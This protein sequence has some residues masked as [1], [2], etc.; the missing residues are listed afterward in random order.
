M[1]RDFIY[2]T[3]NW[4]KMH[5]KPL[6]RKSH[7]RKSL[8]WTDESYVLGLRT[9]GFRNGMSHWSIAEFYRKN[10]KK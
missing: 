7:K 6:R 2:S 4:L 8:L 5:H 9:S 3:N 1:D 10:I